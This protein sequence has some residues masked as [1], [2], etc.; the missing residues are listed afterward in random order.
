MERDVGVSWRKLFWSAGLE[1][2]GSLG[3]FWKKGWR[4]A[5]GVRG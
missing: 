4:G 2:V 1:E 5:W 3:F